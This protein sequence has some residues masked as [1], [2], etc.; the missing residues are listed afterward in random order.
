VGA[1][2]ILII[3][4]RYRIA[5]GED[6]VVEAEAR[7]LRERGHEVLV[8]TRSNEELES[9]SVVGRTAAALRAVWSRAAV[10]EV[11]ARV[12]D[13]RPD[14]AHVHN[15]FHV[16]SPAVYRALA[17]SGVPVVQTLHNY[18]LLC[19]GALFLRDGRVCEDCL[20]RFFAWPGVVH[21]CYRGSLG[22]S[23]GVAGSVAAHRLL[24]TWE[25]AV[26]LYIALTQFAR[27]KF[28]AAG[29]PP[30]R[31]VV[32]PNF[33]YP[34]ASERVRRGPGDFF[35][36]M[37]RL[38]PEKGVGT[39]LSTWRSP[40]LGRV[41]LVLCGDGPLA[42]EVREAAAA[43]GGAIRYLGRVGP[44][45]IARLMGEARALLFP[46]LWYEAFPLVIAEAYASG[47]PVL[48]SRLGA[49]AELV[50]DGATGAL[51]PP[52]EPEAWCAGVLWAWREPSC[53][54]AM[55]E[56]AR[57]VYEERYS[58]EANYRLLLEIYHRVLGKEVQEGVPAAAI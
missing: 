42:G 39:L 13:F 29:F 36:Y 53:L 2:R 56:R 8:H 5:G 6:R 35:L 50:E 28:I 14:V 47:L 51:L 41:P 40:E 58:P 34:P 7:L 4:N 38:S 23:L 11:L 33:V 21:R 49:A 54:S 55:G 37:G 46:S 30:E 48:A 15:V 45:E 1:L 32:K 10:R 25:R 12:R 3:H 20:G 9:G 44:E 57:R 26:S 31:V 18:R 16:I 19:P 22:A 43:S 52:G 27:S 17:R 24:G